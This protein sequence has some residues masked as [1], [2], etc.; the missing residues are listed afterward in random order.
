MP[1]LR[2]AALSAGVAAF[3]V[4]FCEI[5]P[6]DAS[7]YASALASGGFDV[8]SSLADVEEWP[9]AIK[10]GHLSRIK[11]QVAQQQEAATA[12]REPR[13]PSPAG[14]RGPAALE[15][16]ASFATLGSHSGQEP[17]RLYEYAGLTV[18]GFT[19]SSGPFM[20]D[21]RKD[22]RIATMLGSKKE[23]HDYAIQDM[24]AKLKEEELQEAQRKKA[25]EEE[26]AIIAA[27][28]EAEETEE[29]QREME[30]LVSLN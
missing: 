16:T 17:P 28:K 2:V 27:A 29:A 30:R 7:A 24:E 11:R 22:A 13:E 1:W 10:P 26:A 25:A 21:Q 8:V 23:R 12:G 19:K 15:R 3:L 20:S 14:S 18:T 6:A 9:A 5:P 4:S